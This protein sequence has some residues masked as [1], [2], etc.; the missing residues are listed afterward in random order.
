[1]SLY[2]I[3]SRTN[4]TPPPLQLLSKTSTKEDEY[5]TL[6]RGPNTPTSPNPAIPLDDTHPPAAH[7][8]PKLDA[9]LE[10]ELRRACAVILRDLKPSG[11][12]LEDTRM[13]QDILVDGG[14]DEDLSTSIPKDV[15]KLPVTRSGPA[16]ER[17]R[18][19]KKH[20]K[21]LSRRH[22]RYRLH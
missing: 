9:T 2:R 3:L 20:E 5:P 6:S 12:D 17:N 21:L 8:R 14:S 18:P 11:H 7:R 10:I 13:K 15:P 1:M 16:S 4:K 19:Q 22:G